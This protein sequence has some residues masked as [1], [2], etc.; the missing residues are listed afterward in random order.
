MCIRDRR[1][2]NHAFTEKSK[3]P[4]G[5][6]PNTPSLHVGDIVYL[7]S[8]KE[9]SRAC[10]YLVVSIVLPWCF[11]KKFR[12]FQLGATSYKVKLSECYAVPPSVLVPDD[13]GPQASQDQDD[14]PSQVTPALPAVSVPPETPAPALPELTSM[15][16]DEVQFPSSACGDTTLDAPIGVPPLLALQEELRTIATAPDQ[17]LSSLSLIHI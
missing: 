16:S 12:G 11:I 7:I 1:S 15:L 2:T 5:L 17:A 6:V 8:D 3:N 13:S 14:E 9:K 10:R 4:H